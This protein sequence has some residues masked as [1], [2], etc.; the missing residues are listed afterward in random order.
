MLMK[1]SDGDSATIGA[2]P[3]YTWNKSKRKGLATYDRSLESSTG[4]LWHQ[5]WGKKLCMPGA[6]HTAPSVNHWT[7]TCHTHSLERMALDPPREYTPWKKRKNSSGEHGIQG[8]TTAIDL[9]FKGLKKKQLMIVTWKKN[10]AFTHFDNQSNQLL[11]AHLKGPV[12]SLILPHLSGFTTSA[13]RSGSHS[14]S[15]PEPWEQLL[16]TT[17]ITGFASSGLTSGRIS[18]A[19]VFF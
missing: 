3:K 10:I 5:H 19:P 12:V 16:N 15:G 17:T 11:L 7:D 4:G 6:G 1:F 8:L 18:L 2:I 14:G 13:S 9:A